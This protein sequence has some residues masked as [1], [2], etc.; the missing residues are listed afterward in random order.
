MTQGMKLCTTELVHNK[1]N[2]RLQ[3]HKH[4]AVHYNSLLF[5]KTFCLEMEPEVTQLEGD[6]EAAKEVF[7]GV[8]KYFG[9]NPKLSQPNSIFPALHRFRTAFNKAHMDNLEKE[10]VEEAVSE[11][12]KYLLE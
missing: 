10:R 12:F 4:T 2:K 1:A 9:E 8:V 11:H 3:V 7:V 6:Y 5:F